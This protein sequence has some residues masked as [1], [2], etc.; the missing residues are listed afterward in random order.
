MIEQLQLEH[1]K[2]F[3]VIASVAFFFSFAWLTVKLLESSRREEEY[4][5]WHRLY[6]GATKDLID[7]VNSM[8]VKDSRVSA[9]ARRMIVDMEEKLRRD[10][11]IPRTELEAEGEA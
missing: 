8:P 4:A 11:R 1:W 9:L 2:A 5:E 6:A 10:D 7:I 3:A